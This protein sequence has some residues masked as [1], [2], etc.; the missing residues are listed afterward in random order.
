ME[1]S[2]EYDTHHRGIRLRLCGYYENPK[3][4]IAKMENYHLR[5]AVKY[6]I[7]GNI[8]ARTCQFL[9]PWQERTCLMFATIGNSAVPPDSGVS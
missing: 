6:S 1:F 5:R 2:G 7:G 3:P 9:S 8:Q 4:D